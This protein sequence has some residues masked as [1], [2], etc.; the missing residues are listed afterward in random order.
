MQRLTTNEPTDDQL[1]IA[2]EALKAATNTPEAD[3]ASTCVL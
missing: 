2:L 1:E 3:A